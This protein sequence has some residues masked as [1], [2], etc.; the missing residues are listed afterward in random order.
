MRKETNKVAYLNSWVRSGNEHVTFNPNCMH[1]HAN[2]TISQVLADGFRKYGD[3]VDQKRV[4]LTLA[5]VDVGIMVMAYS[6]IGKPSPPPLI[7]DLVQSRTHPDRIQ[8]KVWECSYRFYILATWTLRNS[9]LTM[10]SQRNR[11]VG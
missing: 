4:C 6:N 2:L 5:N 7:I 3:G 9:S 10:Y 11:R 8:Q 1:P